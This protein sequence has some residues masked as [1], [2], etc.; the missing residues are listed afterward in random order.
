[1]AE[2]AIAGKNGAICDGRRLSVRFADRD[3]DKGLSS[4]PSRN[5]YV[6]NLPQSMTEVEVEELFSK[7]GEILSLRVLK[8]LST[9][10]F[11]LPVCTW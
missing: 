4:E 2:A 6:A 8:Y 3:K 1:M 5:L 9:G 11:M 7:Y 10:V